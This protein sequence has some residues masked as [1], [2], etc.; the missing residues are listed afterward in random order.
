MIEALGMNLGFVALQCAIELGVIAL[1]VLFLVLS[2]YRQPSKPLIIV[3]GL[4]T[5]WVMVYACASSAFGLVRFSFRFNETVEDFSLVEQISAA[6]VP[7]TRLTFALGILLAIFYLFH[8]VKFPRHSK[9]ERFL[10]GVG[11][12]CA[13]LMFMPV[14]YLCFVSGLLNHRSPS[15]DPEKGNDGSWTGGSYPTG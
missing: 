8:I 2:K 6:L 5:A 13:P 3:I 1:I 15:L 11:L 10:Y 12:L 9:G 14:Y 4:A 7:V